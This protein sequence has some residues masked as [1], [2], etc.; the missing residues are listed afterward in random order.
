MC[1]KKIYSLHIPFLRLTFNYFAVDLISCT[2]RFTDGFI[3]GVA[4][5][6][7]L[8]ASILTMYVIFFPRE[9]SFELPSTAQ[10]ETKT[11]FVSF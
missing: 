3:E 6:L 8:K 4:S 11:L 7:G 1:Q 5:H 2:S 10:Q 9:M